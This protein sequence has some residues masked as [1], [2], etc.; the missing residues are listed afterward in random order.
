MKLK[1]TGKRTYTGDN[2]KKMREK[3]KCNRM[4][5]NESK[6][7]ERKVSNSKKRIEK[8]SRSKGRKSKESEE[9]LN[10]LKSLFGEENAKIYQE[11]IQANISLGK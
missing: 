7:E 4:T 2:F 8:H 1:E 11:F 5:E 6:P 3:F 9:I 10:D